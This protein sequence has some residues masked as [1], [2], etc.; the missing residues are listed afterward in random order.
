[1]LV[2]FIERV[3]ADNNVTNYIGIVTLETTNP[4]IACS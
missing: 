3:K 4:G 1:M 2:V